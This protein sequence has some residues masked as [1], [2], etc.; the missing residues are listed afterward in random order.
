[1]AARDQIGAFRRDNLEVL[2]LQKYTNNIRVIILY[3]LSRG[4]TH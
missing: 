1:M 2:T 4:L 3:S